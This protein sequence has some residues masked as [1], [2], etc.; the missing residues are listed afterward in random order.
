MNRR[1]LE[2]VLEALAPSGGAFPEGA[3]SFPLVDSTEEFVQSTGAAAGFRLLLRA[4]DLSPFFLRP[5]KF[6]RF[7]RLSLE[8]REQ[9]LEAW[10]SS[11]FWPRRQVLRAFKLLALSQ[12]YAR[13]EVQSRLGY[14]HP[15]E[16]V[17]LDDSRIQPGETLETPAAPSLGESTGVI[18][19]GTGA[20]GAV[21]AA[22][23]AEAG[24][25]VVML[26]EG[27]QHSDRDFT[28][29]ALT[30]VRALYRQGGL[31]GAIGNTYIPIPL[32]CAV[33]GTTTINSGTCWR[34]PETVLARWETEF[35]IP[36]LANGGLAGE[37]ERVEKAIGVGPVPESLLG[38][39][40]RRMRQGAEALGFLGAPIP[41]NAVGCRGTGVCV[42]GCPRGAKQSMN[43]SYVPR[44]L[45]A[46]ARLYTRCRVDQIWV[47]AGKARGV[48]GTRLDSHGQPEGAFSIRAP[49]VVVAAGAL[50]TP[51]LLARSGLAGRRSC[52]GRH[53]RIHP[54]TRVLGRFDEPIR[55]WEGVP[56]SY[57]VHEFEPEGIFLQ[58]MWVPPELQAPEVPGVGR[59]H[60]E[61][62]AAYAQMASFGALISD[63]S[64]G[65]VIGRGGQPLVWYRMNRNDVR[66]LLRGIS[67][68]A[69]M[70]FAAGAREVY[71]GVRQQPILDSME[72]AEALE[73]RRV[74]AA[75]LDMMAFHPM[76]TAR[77][78]SHPNRSAVD[79]RGRLRTATGVWVAD[80]SLFPTSTRVNPQ[81]TIMAL[82][83]RVAQSM[84]RSA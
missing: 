68:V 52:I 61:R 24:W 79:P 62:M 70:F 28:A 74:R 66:R 4:I 75:D 12:F 10:E 72:A 45:A 49:R 29:E 73:Q 69:R 32:G 17:P 6:R 5:F 33:G 13:P 36:N 64:S 37:Y 27:R 34:T 31:T 15:L 43:V 38:P 55:A 20:G 11:R 58:G 77:M 2:S 60:K 21:V 23:L 39:G 46:G 50:L 19:V 47:E 51:G 67:I 42:F 3:Q 76:G 83:T 30:Q 8:E 53:L 41:R 48:R 44:A 18:V 26:E 78:G 56:Q 1:L 57:H 84:T 22:E 80:A 7:S 54:A 9:I 25:E 35:G 16:R 81:L 82:A 65:R 14:V 71:S 59:I 63:T 40:D